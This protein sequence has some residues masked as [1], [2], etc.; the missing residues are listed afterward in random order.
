MFTFQIL[1]DFEIRNKSLDAGALFTAWPKIKTEIII[2][3]NVAE[4]DMCLK[5]YNE[6]IGY[7]LAL[8]KL[9]I[10]K[11]AAFDEIVS[12]FI[13]FSDVRCEI[14]AQNQILLFQ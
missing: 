3:V 5:Y 10:P 7:F 9:L 12:K 11:N 13:V 14:L 4:R 2:S 6:D 8:L 1:F